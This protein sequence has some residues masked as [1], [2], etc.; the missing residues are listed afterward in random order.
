MY[1]ILKLD[2]LELKKN[3]VWSLKHFHHDTIQAY[4]NNLW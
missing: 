1:H 4:N 3:C 2:N